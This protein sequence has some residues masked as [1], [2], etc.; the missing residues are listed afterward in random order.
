MLVGLFY[1]ALGRDCAASQ[2]RAV[3]LVPEYHGVIGV[4]WAGIG[5]RDRQDNRSITNVQRDRFDDCSPFDLV[6]PSAE[7]AKNRTELWSISG[8][9]PPT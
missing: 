2:H 8:V 4:T 7:P 3:A 9:L 5:Q 6:S 1:P